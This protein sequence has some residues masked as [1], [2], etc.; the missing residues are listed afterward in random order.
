MNWLLKFKRRF[1]QK[2]EFILQGTLINRGA[3]PNL[4]KI[5]CSIAISKCYGCSAYPCNKDGVFVSARVTLWIYVNHM[6]LCHKK[7]HYKTASI[8]SVFFVSVERI[9]RKHGTKQHMQYNRSKK[10]I[11][12][13][14][15]KKLIPVKSVDI[16]KQ[17]ETQ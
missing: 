3:P 2:N 4:A 12:G 1:P 10:H 6:R 16:G 15:M 14:P 7:S 11:G 8:I 9:H 5:P 13:T 17:E